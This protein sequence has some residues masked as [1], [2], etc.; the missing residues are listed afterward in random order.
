MKKNDIFIRILRNN[1]PARLVPA[2]TDSILRPKQNFGYNAVD[3][4]TVCP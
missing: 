1:L 4:V 3:P 2:F